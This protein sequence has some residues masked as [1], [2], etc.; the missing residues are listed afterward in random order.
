MSTSTI[1][2]TNLATFVL[3]DVLGLFGASVQR[4]VPLIITGRGHGSGI[5]WDP[6]DLV[7]TN[8]HVVPGD[9]ATVVLAGQRMAATVVG[10]DP[11][12]DLAALQIDR[13]GIATLGEPLVPLKPRRAPPRAGQLAIA[14]GHP[15]DERDTL[16]IGV[17]TATDHSPAPGAGER[18]WLVQTDVRLR[19][20]HSGGPLLDSVGAVIGVNTLVRGSLS[21]AIPVD[22]VN[23]FVAAVRR[24]HHPPHLGDG[25]SRDDDRVTWL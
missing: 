17:I 20:G 13:A 11:R 22:L 24:G 3:E 8:H 5:V 16:T 18:P 15:R 4:S 12:Y 1:A 6:D 23:A 25:A 14:A 7:I 19:P 2:G 21:L 10:R 9:G